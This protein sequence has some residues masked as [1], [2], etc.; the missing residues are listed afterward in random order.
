MYI[1]NG[2]SIAG[3]KVSQ[4]DVATFAREICAEAASRKSFSVFTL[5]LD[6]IVKLKK[7]ATFR[8]A[9][10]RARF[11]SADGFPIVIAGRLKGYGLKRVAGSDLIDPVCEVAAEQEQ[12]VFFFG[13]TEAV[14]QTS[15]ARLRARHPNLKY[16]GH[17]APPLGFDPLSPAADLAMQR[18]RHSGAAICFVALGAPKQ[19]LFADQ[20]SKVGD[21][22]AMLCIGAGL[23]FIAGKHKRAPRI[24]Q[25]V[26]A[27][28]LWRLASDPRRLAR[29][30][31]SCLAMLPFFLVEEAFGRRG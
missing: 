21:G 20:A 25:C 28:W 4:L 15:I 31:L 8:R 14:L 12:S 16:A 17:F 9:Y 24:L 29:R 13:S 6:H 19:E 27:E 5:N 18:I 23:D 10:S 30:Y 22:P 26:G 7:D 3:V 2:P 11:V 1:F